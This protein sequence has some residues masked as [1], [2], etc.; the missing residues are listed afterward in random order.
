MKEIIIIVLIAAALMLS[1]SIIPMSL[2][3]A[4]VGLNQSQNQTQGNHTGKNNSSIPIA[5]GAL[6]YPSYKPCKDNPG[7]LCSIPPKPPK[8]IPPNNTTTLPP[9]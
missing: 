6:I 5:P 4:K 7:V 9:S 3:Q 2:A 8:P 1:T